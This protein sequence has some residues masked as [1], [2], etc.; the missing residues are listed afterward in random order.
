MGDVVNAEHDSIK[1]LLEELCSAYGRGLLVQ[2][3]DADRRHD[4]RSPDQQLP[5]HVD[6]CPDL[7]VLDYVDAVFQISASIIEQQ[8]GGDPVEEPRRLG[9]EIN[10]IFEEEGVGYRWTDGRLVRFDAEI[11]HTEA[12]VPAIAV[13]ANERFGAAGAE[14]DEAVADFARGAYRDAL[15]NA[16]AALE[17]VLK[18]LTGKTS[19]TAGDLIGEARRQGLIPKPLGASVEN[20]E[21]L[22]HGIPAIRA[23]EGSSHGLGDRTGLADERLARLILTMTAAVIVFLADDGD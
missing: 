23:Q 22:M 15:T 20:L 21:K 18:V 11:T 3:T 6:V 4:L 10:K 9:A 8:G 16:N 12:V 14:F 1:R 13:L 7:E 19:G 2:Y 17:S 5:D